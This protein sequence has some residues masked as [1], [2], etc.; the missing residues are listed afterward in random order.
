MGE[1]RRGVFSAKRIIDIFNNCLA[2][3]EQ[4]GHSRCIVTLIN[5]ETGDY[6]IFA[7]EINPQQLCFSGALITQLA[8]ESDE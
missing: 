6:Q 7:T 3:S 1:V 8:M 4:N 5:P 2:Y